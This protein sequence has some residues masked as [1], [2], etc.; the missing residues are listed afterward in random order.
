MAFFEQ[1]SHEPY[2]ATSRFWIALLR[3]EREF[4]E[5]LAKKRGPG[6]AALQVMDRHLGSHEFFVAGRYT[7]A[8]ICLYAYTHVA[9]E[10]GF[11]L[12]TFPHILAWLERVKAQPRHIGIE[13][14]PG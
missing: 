8:D 6:Y 9:P 3:K 13:H 7:I 12:S 5:E 1:Y 10:G 4:R 14:M 11:D 2:I